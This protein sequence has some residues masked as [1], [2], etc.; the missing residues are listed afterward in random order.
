MEKRDTL[1]I[2]RE[3]EVYRELLREFPDGPAS[4]TIRELIAELEKELRALKE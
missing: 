1:T 2:A 3:I 4:E